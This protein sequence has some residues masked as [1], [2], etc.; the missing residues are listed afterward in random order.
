MVHEA[1]IAAK[2]AT[3]DTMGSYD[4]RRGCNEDYQQQA[5]GLLT[6][7]SALEA[8]RVLLLFRR[9]TQGCPTGAKLRP[10]LEAWTTS[11]GAVILSSNRKA[12]NLSKYANKRFFKLY[13]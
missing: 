1:R 9:R 8:A 10:S 5:G 4:E 12:L 3:T 6:D 7:Q 11:Y 13:S 2:E